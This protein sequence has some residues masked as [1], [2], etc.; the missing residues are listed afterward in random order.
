[1][2]ILVAVTEQVWL[3]DVERGAHYAELQR[4]TQQIWTD[5]LLSAAASSSQAPAAVSRIVFH[6]RDLHVWLTDNADRVDDE[7]RAHRFAMLD[8]LDRFIYREY[9]AKVTNSTV[10]TPPGSPI[11]SSL[12]STLRSDAPDWLRRTTERQAWL[13]E[14]IDA[15]TICAFEPGL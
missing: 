1:L 6:L 5:A 9:D 10:T 7:T 8:Q 11:G 15:T 3:S 12:G 4:Q 13:D 2:D 14:W